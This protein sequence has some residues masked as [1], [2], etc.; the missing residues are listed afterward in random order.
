M[1]RVDAFR[2]SALFTYQDATPHEEAKRAREIK[3][4]QRRKLIL[5]V[6]AI[7]VLLAFPAGGSSGGV[8]L[9]RT[10]Q[11]EGEMRKPQSKGAARTKRVKPGMW[12]GEHIS[13]QVGERN[14]SIEFDCAHA[15]IARV[16][17]LDGRG[18]FSVAGTYFEERG[19]PVREGAESGGYAVRFAGQVE[20]ERMKLTITR[21][22]NRSSKETFTLVHNQEPFLVK[23]R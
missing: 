1:K 22:G 7:T 16:I 14:A 2:V 9:R 15:T 8:A 17:V 10:A 19:G 6:S 18:R 4:N 23:C 3:V 21:A 12:G 5:C 20:G 11:R 13:L